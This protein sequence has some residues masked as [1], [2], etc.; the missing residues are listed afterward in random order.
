MKVTDLEHC[1]AGSHG[2][3][4]DQSLR[5]STLVGL[6]VFGLVPS[7]FTS[8]RNKAPELS[9]PLFVRLWEPVKQTNLNHLLLAVDPVL[10]GWLCYMEAVGISN[11][12]IK[13]GLVPT[14]YI[15]GGMGLPK[16]HKNKKRIIYGVTRECFCHR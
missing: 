11:I 5:C 15:L 2:C 10:I 12:C 13:Y 1:T 14:R 7:S 8:V 6:W 3:V 16:T 9:L 4:S